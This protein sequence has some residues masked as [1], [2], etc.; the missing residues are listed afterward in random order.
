MGDQNFGVLIIAHGSS[1]L[2]WEQELDNTVQSVSS[3]CPITLSYL[4]FSEDKTIKRQIE[5]LEEL[6]VNHI[7]AIPL[8]ISS[9]STHIAEIEYMLGM[10][11]VCQVETDV[12]PIST[13]AKITLC[14]PMDDHPL[15]VDLLINQ[16]RQ[17]SLTPSNEA[18]LLLGHG[19][20]KEDFSEVWQDF[21]RRLEVK[22]K[23]SISFGTV[24]HVTM[25][26]ENLNQIA[27]HLRSQFDRLIVLPLFLCEG[28]FTRKVIPKRL[29]DVDYIIGSTYLPHP[30]VCKWIE[31]QIEYTLSME[32]K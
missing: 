18:V 8:F 6:G 11:N 12:V 2:N 20:D 7:I 4:E 3:P 16:L 1:N 13:N 9:G 28:Y 19:S 21:L 31:Y 24:T 27:R 15:I 25:Y 23:S 29:S 22:I 30:N 10:S 5:A 17:L 14:S 26:H 32:R